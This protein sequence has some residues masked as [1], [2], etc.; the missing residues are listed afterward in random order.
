MGPRPVPRGIRF[1]VS[2][3]DTQL[4]SDIF[5]AELNLNRQVSGNKNFGV[6]NYHPG[7]AGYRSA[8]LNGLANYVKKRL[9]FIRGTKSRRVMKLKGMQD[10][11]RSMESHTLM[12]YQLIEMLRR[13]FKPNY[14]FYPELLKIAKWDGKTLP[15]ELEA[16]ERTLPGVRERLK[17]IQL[18]IVR[19]YEDCIVF[20]IF[21][22]SF[23]ERSSEGESEDRL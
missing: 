16:M 15:W 20:E 18:R 21:P 9:K 12:H 4:V 1:S 17:G 6:H 5:W 23:P 11:R 7:R 19:E 3:S 10:V 13:H 22:S 8:R 2:R 14:E